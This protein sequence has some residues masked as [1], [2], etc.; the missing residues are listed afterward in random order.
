MINLFELA[1]VAREMA[2]R[3]QKSLRPSDRN[4]PRAYA[5]LHQPFNDRLLDAC[6]RVKDNPKGVPGALFIAFPE[7]LMGK[8]A[9]IRGD[10]RDVMGQIST[11]DSHTSTDTSPLLR[12]YDELGKDCRFSNLTTIELFG[13]IKNILL[14]HGLSPIGD[15]I[16]LLADIG[17]AYRGSWVTGLPIRVMLAD[18]SWMSANRS[19]RQFTSLSSDDID[20]GLRV[21]L[22]KRQRL[23]EA[24]GM[25]VDV[26]EILPYARAK[27]INAKKL[28]LISD[29]YR[30]L[31]SCLWGESIL[32]RID[33]N[34]QRIIDNSL[35][36]TKHLADGDIPPH[37]KVL[38]QFP[39]ALGALE[40]ALKPH[41]EI[42][43][44]IAKQFSSFDTE[45]FTYFFAQY[46]AQ[47][48]YC[49]SSLKVAPITEQNFDEPFG[50]LDPY[51]RAWGEGHTTADAVLSQGSQCSNP[52]LSAV[53]LPQYNIGKLRVLPYT[54]L[55]LDALKR[56]ERNHHTLKADLIMLDGHVSAQGQTER[57]LAETPIGQR[58]RLMADLV[59]FF[60]LMSHKLLW[61]D[62]DP[63]TRRAGL[64][65]F[66]E[67]FKILNADAAR[68]FEME[69]E[70]TAQDDVGALWETWLENLP[71]DPDPGFRPTHVQLLCLE[72]DDWGQDQLVAG[73]TICEIA[74]VI[75]QQFL[76]A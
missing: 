23:Y 60:S 22:D 45:I 19:I 34:L 50:R 64:P 15:S 32:G 36:A 21:C 17:R 20:T 18:I 39:G 48:E 8:V 53:Y 30:A 67:T 58:N 63:V 35:D 68:Y 49:G 54:P 57:I 2:D 7:R 1:S 40:A 10:T 70:A 12:Q 44:A 51:F 29:R 3:T 61:E 11:R 31:A 38:G 6:I 72:E 71:I 47:D 69:K 56:E 59:S 5:A 28:Q 42:L 37:V 41:L 14:C 62:I 4:N 46:Y 66:R 43:R 74:R 55:S 52:H 27:K 75:Y 26:H 33:P 13:G 76:T 24:M 9:Y 25:L 16:A 65:T 73:A